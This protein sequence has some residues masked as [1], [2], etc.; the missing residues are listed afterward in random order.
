MKSAGRVAAIWVRWFDI[1]SSEAAVRRPQIAL[2]MCCRAE[3]LLAPRSRFP[4][5][6]PMLWRF[7]LSAPMTGAQNMALD[8]ALMERARQSHQW[9]LRVYAWNP[10]TISFGRNESTRGRYDLGRIHDLG[11]SV[12]RR[13]TGG[14]AILHRR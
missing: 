12:V 1:W 5:P 7:L 2:E 11:L 3:G 10:A 9:V 8:E 4:R 13:P 6:P 14:R